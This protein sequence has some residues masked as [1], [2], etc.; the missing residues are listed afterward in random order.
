MVL[1][2]LQPD[3]TLATAPSKRD[4]QLP[5]EVT[6]RRLQRVYREF[7]CPS[8]NGIRV[9]CCSSTRSCS[10]TQEGMGGRQRRSTSHS[11]ILGR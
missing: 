7:F 10:T 9:R 6:L 5:I 8:Q 11:A 4:G 3:P 2:A 1:R